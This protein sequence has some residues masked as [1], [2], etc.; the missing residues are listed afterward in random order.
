MENRTLIGKLACGGKYN[1]MC[2]DCIPKRYQGI[3]KQFSLM[4]DMVKK[5]NKII[6]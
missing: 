3:F 2:D 6:F 1:E 5:R 4:I